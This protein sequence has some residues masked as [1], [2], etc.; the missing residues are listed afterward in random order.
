M[1]LE[2][3]K[4]DMTSPLHFNFIHFVQIKGSNHYLLMS[5]SADLL[6]NVVSC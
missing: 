5:V 6:G 3:R 4:R 2:D 1:K